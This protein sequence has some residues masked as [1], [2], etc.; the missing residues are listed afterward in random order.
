MPPQ[1]C[2]HQFTG[3]SE[4]QGSVE[5]GGRVLVRTA[6]PDGAQIQRQLPVPRVP[7]N[8][9]NVDLPVAGHLDG[10]VSGRSETVHPKPASRL[11]A[12]D[13]QGAESDNAGA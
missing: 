1:S 12:G 10:N 13:P 6:G 3:R 9:I 7:R 8:C 4:D 5:G 11:D 2:D